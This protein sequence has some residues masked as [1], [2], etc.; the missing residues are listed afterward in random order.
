MAAKNIHFIKKAVYAKL[1][2]DATLLSLLGSNKIYYSQNLQTPQYPS[3]IYEIVSETDNP[4]NE[5]DTDGKITETTLSVTTFSDSSK[6]EESDN[7]DARIKALLHGQSKLTTS[8]IICYSC[9][10]LYSNQRRDAE[11]KLWITTSVYRL[12]S[13][14]VE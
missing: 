8:D 12:T 4:Y 9:F 3:I 7:I 10:K 14:P 1:S 2:A 5:N 11:K 13:A 6:S